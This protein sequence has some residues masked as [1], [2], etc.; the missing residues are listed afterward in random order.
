MRAELKT[1]VESAGGP[2]ANEDDADGLEGD[3][4]PPDK[5]PDPLITRKRSERVWKVDPTPPHLAQEIPIPRLTLP[6]KPLELNATF[7]EE[8][9]QKAHKRLSLIHI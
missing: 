2:Q 4:E 9:N 7:F 5:P 8:L 3:K 6:D 1:P